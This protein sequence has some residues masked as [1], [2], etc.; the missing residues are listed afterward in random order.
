MRRN[1]HWIWAALGILVLPAI[2]LV[3]T[4]GATT[5]KIPVLGTQYV[6][7]VIDPGATW[8]SGNVQHIRGFTES[9]VIVG[10]AYIAGMSIVTLN[11]NINLATGKATVWGTLDLELDA[12]DGGFAGTW[13]GT[14]D[15]FLWS[16]RSTGHGFGDLDGWQERTEMEGIFGLAHTVEGFAF[17]PG[18]EQG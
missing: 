8:T 16:G 17:S 15:G 4:A 13:T 7:G 14:A 10:T 18:D 11:A 12:Y 9:T 1:T 3:G 6:T 5:T 2:V